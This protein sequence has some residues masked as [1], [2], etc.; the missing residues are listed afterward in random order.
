LTDEERT[1][2]RKWF[3]LKNGIIEDKD[4]VEFRT[5]CFPPEVTIF[6]ITGFASLLHAEV[7]EGKIWLKDVL[8]Y[9]S[10]IEKKNGALWARWN[11]PEYMKVRHANVAENIQGKPMIHKVSK[12]ID[13][14]V[15]PLFAPLPRK[16]W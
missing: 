3:L 8:S 5:E 2:I 15:K 12:K 16:R 13:V 10:W 9:T 11:N 4:C 1:K 6:Q 7:A 14:W